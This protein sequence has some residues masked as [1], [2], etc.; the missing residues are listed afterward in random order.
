MDYTL[1][2]TLYSGAGK[3]DLSNKS[4]VHAVSPCAGIEGFLVYVVFAAQFLD[5]KQE[6][7]KVPE[8]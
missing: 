8:P 1:N 5:T 7:V 3:F 2:T 6:L 4:V